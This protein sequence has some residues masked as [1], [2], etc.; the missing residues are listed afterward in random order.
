MPS[1]KR[2]MKKVVVAI[3]AAALLTGGFFVYKKHEEIQFIA[4][5]SPNVKNASIRVA[6]SAKLETEKSSITF[7]ELFDHV[8]VDTAEIEKRSIDV[9]SLATKDNAE[10]TTPVIEYLRNCQEFSRAFAMKYRKNFAFS[11]AM[12]RVRDT[13]DDYR[14]SSYSNEFMKQRRDKAIEEMNKA[15]AEAEEAGASLVVATRQ[16]KASRM[17]LATLMPDDALVQVPQ[18]D[19]VIE[20]NTKKAD[21]AKAEKASSKQ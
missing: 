1:R 21:Q 17:K 3:A 4:S 12:D 6:N 18:L 11:N 14:N 8:D 2:K 19:S 15:A 20:S 10:I 5:I 16:L 13:L 7:K 9:Q